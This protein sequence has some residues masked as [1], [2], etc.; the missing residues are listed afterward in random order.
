MAG[1]K[2]NGFTIVSIYICVN[3]LNINLGMPNFAYMHNLPLFGGRYRCFNLLKDV[4][5]TAG[6]EMFKLYIQ[7]EN[8][9]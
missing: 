1:S 9:A 6:M 4:I 3:M 7:N 5:W 2:Y 8:N